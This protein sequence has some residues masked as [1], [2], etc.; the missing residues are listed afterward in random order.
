MPLPPGQPER[1]QSPASEALATSERLARWIRIIGVALAIYVAI[2]VTVA[3]WFG[4]RNSFEAAE[5]ARNGAT[6]AQQALD[7]AKDNGDIAKNLET[8]VAQQAPCL[9]GDPPNTPACI[10]KARSDAVVA[11]AIADIRESM[12]QSLDTHDIT[13]KADHEVLSVQHRARVTTKRTPITAP[14]RTTS[15]TTTTKAPTRTPAQTTSPSPPPPT[16]TT[17]CPKKGNSGKCR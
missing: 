10:R 2:A 17:T 11:N 13:T 8:L 16:T 12:A 3:S 14:P 1:R 4:V 5:H 7:Q 6:Y 15:R 9:E